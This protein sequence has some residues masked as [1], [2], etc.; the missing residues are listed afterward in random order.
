M[1]H[2]IYTVQ[3][4][5]IWF[6]LQQQFVRWSIYTETVHFVPTPTPTVQKYFKTPTNL[7]VPSYKA[8]SPQTEGEK[9]LTSSQSAN[10]E[11][12][13]SLPGF[14]WL[15]PPLGKYKNVIKIKQSRGRG[16][17]TSLLH[18]TPTLTHV[19]SMLIAP[20]SYQAGVFPKNKDKTFAFFLI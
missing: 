19:C 12:R 16:R 18:T 3:W 13:Q 14:G 20:A 1:S 10:W 2:F 17:V 15:P 11:L 4:R 5:V 7:S 8:A 9:S 6:I